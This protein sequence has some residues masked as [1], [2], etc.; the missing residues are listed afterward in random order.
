MKRNA[1][2]RIVIYSIIA[3]VLTG[4]LIVGLGWD[5]F[6]FEWDLGGN[7]Q[8]V[9][10]TGSADASNIKR[11][12]IEWVDGRVDVSTAQQDT[13]TFS[14][15]GG[16]KHPMVYEIKGNT[17]VIRYSKQTIKFGIHTGIM[18]SK[19]LTVHVPQDWVGSAIEITAVSADITVDLPKVEEAEFENVSG[20]TR[21]HLKECGSVSVETVSGKTIFEGSF[22]QFD[23]NTISGNCEVTLYGH[24]KEIGMESVSGDLTVALLQQY[25]FTAQLDSVSGHI[26]SDFSTSVSGSTHRFGDGSIKIEAETVS[27]NIH[28]KEAAAISITD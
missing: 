26:R 15:T 23:C 19:Q 18:P 7:G 4:I 8:T 13:I 11:I 14:E 2:A 20:N 1:I 9:S 17:L 5:G 25:G 28:I 22:G 21:M 24:A 12:C 10:G 16:E 27:G 6:E 3:V